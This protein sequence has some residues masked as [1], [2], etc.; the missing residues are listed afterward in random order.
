MPKSNPN[1]LNVRNFMPKVYTT[2]DKLNI[3]KLNMD[4]MTDKKFETEFG[5]WDDAD[6][7]KGISQYAKQELLW[8][9][10]NR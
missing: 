8:K 9:R 10:N 1:D 2:S 4:L 7:S 6:Y 5:T 3:T